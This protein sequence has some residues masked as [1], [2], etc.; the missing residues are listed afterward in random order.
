MPVHIA[1]EPLDCVAK[2]TGM[3]LEEI[4]SLKK[5]LITPKKLS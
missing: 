5:I 2:G 1:D 4:D 3:A